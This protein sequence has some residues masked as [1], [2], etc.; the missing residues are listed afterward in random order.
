[1]K[2]K[3]CLAVLI[4]CFAVA[5]DAAAQ[6]CNVEEIRFTSDGEGVSADFSS[7]DTSTCAL[8]IETTVHVESS[9]GI[10]SITDTCGTGGNQ[11][12]TDTTEVSNVVAV[13]LSV[14]NRCLGAQVY[15]VTATGQADEFHISQNFKTA[16]LRAAFEGTDD[17]D[18]AVSIDIDLVWNGVGQK[19]RHRDQVNGSQG[20]AVRFRY[21]SSGIMRDA[22]AAGS[23]AVNGVDKTPFI[24]IRGTIEKDAARGLEMWR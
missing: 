23:V 8:G 5:S 17:S 22:I 12:S 18:Q 4:A 24:S 9:Y 15:A 21:F 19:E 20:G 16:N 6:I 3:V 7:V 14:Y 13:F 11:V 2:T 10:L 1:M